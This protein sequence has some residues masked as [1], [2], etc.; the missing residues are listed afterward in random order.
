M[1]TLITAAT[2][3]IATSASASTIGFGPFMS[4]PGGKTEAPRKFA[5]A[6]IVA[7]K[8]CGWDIQSPKKEPEACMVKAGFYPYSWRA[9][10]YGVGKG[11][12]FTDELT[13]K[14]LKRG[15]KIFGCAEIDTRDGKVWCAYFT[16]N[17]ISRPGWN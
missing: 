16:Q 8:K 17:V 2:V 4:R 15:G 13:Q 6:Y 14:D 3:L 11:W 7:A 5:A 1:R 10:A 12:T 9:T